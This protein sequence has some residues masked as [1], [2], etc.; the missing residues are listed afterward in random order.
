[1]RHAP[2][3]PFNVHTIRRRKSDDCLESLSADEV[4]EGNASEPTSL[5]TGVNMHPHT[6]VDVPGSSTNVPGSSTNA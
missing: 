1:M 3:T 2:W 4:F 6:D 5:S